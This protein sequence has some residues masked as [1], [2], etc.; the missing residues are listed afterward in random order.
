MRRAI[1]GGTQEVYVPAVP[2]GRSPMASWTTV[3]SL[4]RQLGSICSAAD[5]A[6]TSFS[7]RSAIDE[8]I[9]EATTAVSLTIED[10]PNRTSA[11]LR[12]RSRHLIESAQRVASPRISDRGDQLDR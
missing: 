2:R 12:A 10:P 11:H 6:T 9:R 8:A 7:A 5:V 3:E 1:D 4:I